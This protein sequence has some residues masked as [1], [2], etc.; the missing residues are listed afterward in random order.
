MSEFFFSFVSFVLYTVLW[1]Q[2]KFYERHFD[3]RIR[4]RLE[5]FS[6]LR[7]ITGVNKG[8]YISGE[9]PFVRF[10]NLAPKIILTVS[11]LR[12]TMTGR[13]EP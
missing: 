4:L 1:L 2:L 6:L 5:F 8:K 9:V 3:N 12:S 7:L 10:Y 13:Y 11:Q